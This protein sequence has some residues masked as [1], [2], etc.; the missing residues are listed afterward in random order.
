LS[1]IPSVSAELNAAY[2]RLRAEG[3]EGWGGSKF[4]TRLDGWRKELESWRASSCLPRC[5]RVLE[6]GCGNGAVTSLFA[7]PG[8]E[9]A[10]VDVSE[11]AV[12]WARQS[13]QER[14]LSA[15]FYCDDLTQGLG[16]FDD[17]AFNL[18]VDGNCLHCVLGEDRPR[19]LA[20][21]RRI[22]A[23]D[24]VFLLSSMCGPPR[25]PEAV[26]EFDPQSTCLRREG[27]PY[28]YLP[29]AQSLVEEV[30]VAGFNPVSWRVQT[31]QWWDHMW[32]I[33]NK[34]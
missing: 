21:I 10:G 26:A 23:D 19:T 18:V 3:H 6:L 33:A 16:R 32:M 4:P 28:R 30:I 14:G 17:R 22:L 1:K 29:P 12:E 9:V 25:S 5:G 24:G 2:D 11:S 27:R 8:Y 31:N 7:L 13:F 15:E 34:R 20:T